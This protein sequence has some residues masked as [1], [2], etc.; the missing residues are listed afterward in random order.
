MTG[1]NVSTL[2]PVVVIVSFGWAMALAYVAMPRKKDL[3]WCALAMALHG[4]AYV[5]FA[6]TGKAPLFVPVVLG[7]AALLACLVLIVEIFLDLRAVQAWRWW[8]APLMALPVVYAFFPSPADVAFRVILGCLVYGGLCV[9]LVWLL[10]RPHPALPGR[11]RRI[12]LTGVLLV[13]SIFLLRLLAALTDHPPAL[14]WNASN[15]VQSLT[16]L[17]ALLGMSLL[18]LG[19]VLMSEERLAQALSL[20]RNNYRLLVENASEG[21]VVVQ[22]GRMK[23]AN[24]MLLSL[25][26][27][28]EEDVLG[29]NLLQFVHEDDRAK[30]AEAYQLRVQGLAQGLKYPL[31]VLTHDRGTRWFEISGT[32]F[33]WEGHP[34]TLNFLTDI[35]DRVEMENQIRSLAYHDSL[36]QLP[37]RV[38]MCDRLKQALANHK[39]VPRYGALMFLDLDN[40]KPVNDAHGHVAGDMVL[41]E[42]AQR[43]M[44][45]VRETD[46]VARF[47]GDEFV[48]MLADLHE[49]R[50]TSLAQA[51]GLADKVL[52]TLSEPYH[53]LLPQHDGS[54]RT[55]THRCGASIGLVLFHSETGREERLL[56]QADSAMYRA[57]EAGRQTIVLAEQQFGEAACA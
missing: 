2:V 47:G 31:R 4:V 48:V 11:G 7:N 14:S 3:L 16:L 8:W 18:V 46:T 53:L 17:A 54:V 33:V 44:R 36:T 9:A 32:H 21:I 10:C 50:L 25:L 13:L 12:T 38:L 30:V 22:G 29:Q 39:R 26:G 34:A 49:D 55:V 27:F 23:F 56:Q 15:V 41:I 1:L 52:H 43:L 40:F 20:S 51:R 45:C 28:A 24:P 6:F 35:Q 42:V 19:V 37:N 57:K 5:C